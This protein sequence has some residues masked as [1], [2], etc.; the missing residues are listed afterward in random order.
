MNRLGAKVPYREVRD[1]LAR[2]CHIKIGSTTIQEQTVQAG[3]QFVAYRNEQAIN[4]KPKEGIESKQPMLLSADGCFICLNNGEWHEV[5]TVLAGEFDKIWSDSEGRMVAVTK[6]ISY[7]S[8][9]QDV[10]AFEQLSTGEMIYR[11]IP[12]AETVVAVQDGATWLVNFT[13]YHCPQAIR[14]LDFRHAQECLGKIGHILCEEKEEQFEEW[15]TKWSHKIIVSCPRKFL[16]TL[17]EMIRSARLEKEQEQIKKLEDAYNYLKKRETMID[18]VQF[19]ERVYP[20]GSGAVE[21]SHKQVIQ[22]RMKQSGMRWKKENIEGMLCLRNA[23]CNDRWT[24]IWN[25][26]Q[27]H[28]FP[29]SA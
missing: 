8:T 2:F 17:H 10:R 14:I 25:A 5:K 27:S 13:D 21:S 18:Y 20:I 23:I 3:N 12:D 1:E 11:G 16:Q 15:Y 22:S 29:L 28:A 6:E 9:G 19:R 26:C 7:C 4:P 24:P